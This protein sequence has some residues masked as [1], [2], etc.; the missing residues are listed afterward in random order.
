MNRKARPFQALLLTVA[1]ALSGFGCSRQY[2]SR[3]EISA[4]VDL[5]RLTRKMEAIQ[6]DCEFARETAP[7]ADASKASRQAR[8][9]LAALRGEL[10]AVRPP[11]KLDPARADLDAAL[12]H[13]VVLY[14]EPPTPAPD[15]KSPP[16][17]RTQFNE[18]YRRLVETLNRCAPAPAPKAG[19]V[20]QPPPPPADQA[21]IKRAM[22]LA[23]LG[24]TSAIPRLPTNGDSILPRCASARSTLLPDFDLTTCAARMT[25][26][27]KTSRRLRTGFSPDA[28][29]KE[30][31]QHDQPTR[32]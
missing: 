11:R 32:V 19:T 9:E 13:L 17:R 4:F 21:A 3:R 14:A 15:T 20:Q 29:K 31:R 25:I 28:A 26:L 27:R 5:N 24:Y 23:E 6:I 18:S 1:L 7:V 16:E 30:N 10:S 12:G 22:G 8:D 2:P